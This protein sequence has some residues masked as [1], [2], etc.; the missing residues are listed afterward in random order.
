MRIELVRRHPEMVVQESAKIGR[1]IAGVGDHFHA[2][3]SGNDH[4]LLDPRMSRELAATIRKAR[5]RNCQ[6]FAHF[7]WSA[8]MIHADELISHD[9]ANLWIVEK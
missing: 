6:A 8:L 3:A 7:E 1:A 2:V 4:T 5:L 9:A